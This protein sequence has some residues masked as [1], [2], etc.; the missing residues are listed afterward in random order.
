MARRLATLALFWVLLWPLQLWAEPVSTYRIGV[1]VLDPKLERVGSLVVDTG[2]TYG[3]VVAMDAWRIDSFRTDLQLKAERLA[4]EQHLKAY[5]AKDTSALLNVSVGSIGDLPSRMDAVYSLVPYESAFRQLAT[6]DEALL[7]LRRY[8]GYDE[9][10]VLRAEELGSLVRITLEGFTQS[11]KLL[12][13]RLTPQYELQA[14]IG[15]ELGTILLSHAG[16]LSLGALRLVSDLPVL[17]LQING[18]M[19]EE[20]VVLLEKGTYELT[21][22]ADGY[23]RKSEQIEVEASKIKTLSVELDKL[24]L[25]DAVLY[26][27]GGVG[28]WYIDGRAV[29]SSLSITLGQV[30]Y[31]VVAIFSKPGFSDTLVQLEKPKASVSVTPSP[32]ALD[33]D[34]LLLDQQKDFYKRLRNTILWFGAYIGAF[35]LSNTLLKDSPLWQTAMIGTSSL[36]IVSA[37]ALVSEGASYAQQ[38]G[39]L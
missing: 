28:T 19:V 32:L 8:L 37:L 21:F 2:S 33:Q 22:E 14:I 1:V 23:Q 10:L 7:W 36:A 15:E 24:A 27:L 11:R 35:T 4:D 18:K 39:R 9:L 26:S 5:K 13:N 3:K 12:L 29:G 31:P 30:D 20:R 6:E 17:K 16:D 38:A 25:S 34:N